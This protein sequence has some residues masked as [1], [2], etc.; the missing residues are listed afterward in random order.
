MC[1]IHRLARANSF[2]LNA[3]QRAN[4]MLVE[5]VFQC[6]MCDKTITYEHDQVA[7]KN[8]IYTFLIT[9]MCDYLPYNLAFSYCA[10]HM[11]YTHM[12][13][14]LCPFAINN[15]RVQSSQTKC[16][17]H[18]RGTYVHVHKRLMRHAK[19]ARAAFLWC[20]V[21]ASVS[22]FMQAH[23]PYSTGYML[24]RLGSRISKPH[25]VYGRVHI[26]TTFTS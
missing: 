25:G 15:T 24:R 13:H 3:I 7:Q 19:T 5:W 23:K 22:T 17:R 18:R 26:C 12:L 14:R 16:R 10:H 21:A 8:E 9:T 2:I 6:T 4:A 20:H 11:Q 1:W